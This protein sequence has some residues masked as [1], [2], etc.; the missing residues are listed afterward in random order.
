V[1][2]DD[3][4]PVRTRARTSLPAHVD[5]V[6][7]SLTTLRG[8]AGVPPALD[9][10]LEG[11]VRELDRARAGARSLRG[12]A[13]TRLLDRLEALDGELLAAAREAC[14]PERLAALRAEAETDLEAFRARMPE[15]AY[16]HAAH[17]A[18]DRLVR[19]AAGLP[20]LAFE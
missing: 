19:D 8:G 6:I 12:E 7:L 3:S 13:R 1:P 4:E 18:V 16:R 10:A 14:G 20:T 17:A 5:R 11:A 2:C 9:A 15:A